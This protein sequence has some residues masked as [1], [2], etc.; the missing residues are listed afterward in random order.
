MEILNTAESTKANTFR[1]QGDEFVHYF[2]NIPDEVLKKPSREYKP[3][4]EGEKETHRDRDRKTG[5]DLS[6]QRHG[7]GSLTR[8]NGCWQYPPFQPSTMGKAAYDPPL[9]S[10]F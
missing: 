10:I 8:Q 2:L 7:K 3:E 6:S 9:P 4:K 5:P 1:T